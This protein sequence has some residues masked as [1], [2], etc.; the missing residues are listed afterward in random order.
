M[1]T[2]MRGRRLDGLTVVWDWY[3]TFAALV[4]LARPPTDLA[5]AE[6]GLLP[7]YS[8]NLWPYLSGKVGGCIN[9]NGLYVLY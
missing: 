1:P 3:A 8:L 9:A 7:I 2:T 4:G 5:A 6:A